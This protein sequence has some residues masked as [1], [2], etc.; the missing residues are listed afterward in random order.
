MS[1]RRASCDA[2]R[3][4]RVHSAHVGQDVEIHYRWHPLYGRRV[5]QQYIEQ[6]AGGPVV[7]VE[8]A[9]GEVIV[10]AAWMLDRAAC[11]NMEMGAPRISIEALIE[12]HRLLIER[13]FRRSSHGDL[14]IAKEEQ[15]EP[16]AEIASD[17]TAACRNPAPAQHHV[18]LRQTAGP[19]RGGS[20]ESNRMLGQSLDASGGRRDGG[21]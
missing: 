10:L 6:R 1:R 14:G 11:A 21:A 4:S 12:L 18:R 17:D 9:P 5:P 2:R 19:R 13:G 7:H 15:N 8:A 3:Q 20:R 16:F